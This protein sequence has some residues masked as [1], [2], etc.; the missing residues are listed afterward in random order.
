MAKHPISGKEDLNT[1]PTSSEFDEF[2]GSAGEREMRKFRRSPKFHRGVAIAVVG[3][4]GAEL[5]AGME[6]VLEELLYEIRALRVA[7]VMVGAA[8]DLGDGVENR[9]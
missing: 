5:G 3:G 4:D 9:V 1:H 2:P 8:G 7:M 6:S